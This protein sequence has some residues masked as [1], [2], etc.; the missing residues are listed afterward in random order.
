MRE[1]LMLKE[2]YDDLINIAGDTPLKRWETI[3]KAADIYFDYDYDDKPDFNP[4]IPAIIIPEIYLL[5]DDEY[6]SLTNL[7]LNIGNDI[8][9]SDYKDEDSQN[10]IYSRILEILNTEIFSKFTEDLL[11]Q[12][13]EFSI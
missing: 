1:K 3:F 12:A 7:I 8:G 13:I 11:D 6:I 10:N 9:I 2:S 4:W 5:N